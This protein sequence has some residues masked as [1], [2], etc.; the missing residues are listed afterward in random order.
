MVRKG[1]T[2]GSFKPLTEES[3]GKVHQTAMRI[4][5]EVGFEVNSGTALELFAQAGARVDRERR[6]V[7]LTGDKVMELV[8]SING[9][10]GV[11]PDCARRILSIMIVQLL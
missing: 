10:D 9:S 4:I 6:R 3:V 11:S 7:C 2:G 1:L 5:E 8:S